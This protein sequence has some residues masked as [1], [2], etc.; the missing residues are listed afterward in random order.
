MTVG[1]VEDG[2]ADAYA[3][4]VRAYADAV[5]EEWQRPSRWQPGPQLRAVSWMNARDYAGRFLLE[6]LQNGHDAHPR[7]RGDG[8]VH[9]LLDEGEGPHGTLY[10]AN[11]G[12]PFLWEKVERVCKLAQSDKRVGEGIGNKGLGFR[13]VLEITES[14]EIYSDD[15]A[16]PGTGRL[17]GYR[18]RFAGKDD[19]R[20][21]LGGDDALVDMVV[22]EYPPLQVPFPV[23]ELP[24]TCA[25]LGAAGHVT[26][27]R[28]PLRSEAAG[29]E[30]ARRLKELARARTPVML[31]LDRLDRLVLERRKADGSV[32]RTDLVR[33]EKPAGS[34]RTRDERG[35]DPR[36]APV[37]SVSRVGLGELGEFLVAR[38]AVPDQRLRDTVADAVETGAL[39]ESWLRWEEAAVVEVALPAG[40]EADRRGQLYTFLP[41]G[42]DMAAPL[43]GHVNAPFFT[44]MDRTDL[45]REHPLNTMLYD[46]LAET[47]LLAAEE[48]RA[49]PGDVHRAAAVDVLGWETGAQ[50]AGL[51]AT[52]ARR[53]HGRAFEDV[54]LVP[55]LD[56]AGPGGW[57]TPREAVLWPAGDLTTLTARS[58]GAVGIPVADPR[59]GGGRMRRLA[60]VCAYLKCPLEPSTPDRAG[61]VERIVAVLPPPAPGEP[62]G[63]WDGVYTDLT[64]LFAGDGAA[65]RGRKLLLADDG[66]LGRCNAGHWREPGTSGRT[67]RR[68]A[69]FQ[70]VRGEA[71]HRGEPAVPDVLGK[72]LFYLHSGLLGTEEGGARHEEARFFLELH[73]LVRKFDVD[74]LLEHVR[75]ALGESS[76]RRL[77]EQA[78]KFVFRLYRSRG[79]ARPLAVK[80]L[81]LYVPSAAGSTILAGTAA[82][83][84]GWRGTHGDDLAAV[85]DE[86][87]DA[88]SD[89][90]GLEARLVAPPTAFVGRG[91][92]LEEW[93]D[94]LRALGVTDG[95]IPVSSGGVDATAHGSRLHTGSLVRM[96]R[97]PRGVVEQWEPFV[98]RGRGTVRYPNTPYRGTPFHR[99][100]GQEVVGG[101]SEPGRLAYARLVLHGLSH[102]NDRRFT[103][104]WT[105]ARSGDKDPRKVLTPLR[106]FVEE[107]PWLPVRGRDR[108]IAFVRPADAWHHP[109]A[110]EEEPAFAPTVA[111]RFRGLLD[112]GNTL[113][114][115]RELG[116]PT[117]DEPRDSARLVAYLGRAVGAGL[118]GP[119]DR[120]AVQRANQRAWKDLTAL[121]DARLRP[122]NVTEPL[123]EA[124]LLVEEGERLV[125]LDVETLGEGGRTL[126]V[127]GE[128]DTLAARLIRE[129]SNPLLVVPGAGKAAAGLLRHLCPDAIRLV[130]E[131]ELSVEVDGGGEGDDGHADLSALGDPLTDRLPWLP[132]AVGALADHATD[133]IRPTD[134]TLTRLVA[135]VRGLRLYGYESLRI[136]FDGTP[137]RL[138]ERLSGILPL[139][140]VRRPLILAPREAARA[141]DWEAVGRLAEA[142]AQLAGQP[143]AALRLR[144]AAHE[145]RTAYSDIATP[146][147]DVLARALGI[148]AAQLEETARRLDGSVAGVLERCLPVLAHILGEPRAR[149]LLDP[150]PTDSREL[151]TLLVP[152]RDALPLEPKDLVAAARIARDVDELRAAAGIDFAEFNRTLTGLGP[153]YRPISRSESHEEAVRLHVDLHRSR[154]VD[155]L[156]W[157]VLDRFDGRRPTA[158]D[159]PG[160][161]SL[162]WI[163]A[164]DSWALTKEHAD[165]ASLRSHIEDELTRRLG[166]SAP[167]QGERLPALE[168]VRS[169]N[170]ALVRGLTGEAVALVNAARKRLPPAL[171]APDPAVEITTLL[172]RAGALDFRDLTADDVLAWLEALGQWPAGMPPTLDAT[173]HGLTAEDLDRVRDDAER[174]REE[175]VRRRSVISFGGTEMDVAAG[176]FTE[177]ASEL[178]RV[179]EAGP[180]IVQGRR[181]FAALQEPRARTGGPTGSPRPGRHPAV[182]RGLSAA[183]RRAI[184]FIGEWFAYRWLREQHEAVNET[185]WVSS[186]RRSVFPGSPGDD[187]LGF[188][189]RVG[190][191]RH[192]L[193]YEVK[194]TQGEGGQIELGESEVRAAQRFAGSER[195]RILAITSVLDPEG[196]GV[197][198]LPNPFSARGRGVYREE[199]GALRFS[200]RM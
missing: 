167:L 129:T 2:S 164:P 86:G 39:D 47:C 62:V 54:P 20:V 93:R 114:R 72:R 92:T 131:A 37:V 147:E 78:L 113:S 8:H 79:P 185:S 187:T 56:P 19:L 59:V 176:D 198:V 17:D 18:F 44:K 7:D 137:I 120:P 57:T 128:R 179:L 58:A 200:Y 50:Y 102:W 15:P 25:E 23:D 150:P 172:D 196:L 66:T 52:A 32:D 103:S 65:L 64:Q 88:S 73:G 98:G 87:R 71:G 84:A 127:S 195:W 108:A 16:A 33:E 191:G 28:L 61:Y 186:N 162:T 166:R 194:A 158:D 155:R 151:V 96:A 35:R 21:L 91:E 130:D 81:G 9:V 42:D 154:L 95:L 4:E 139:P 199:G 142:A 13:S 11:G 184:G 40:G 175:R 126:Y 174:A 182:D 178:Q 90:R 67:A 1:R 119:E 133:G 104:L 76:A 177:L 38:G 53:A 89:L 152:H 68:E 14:P 197:H 134:T 122:W 132:L 27:V 125:T 60:R 156:R 74:G 36:S 181:G 135:T 110:P 136:S 170:G 80:Q 100:P 41:L 6:L 141:L 180:G 183:Q 169:R 83:G 46:A 63:A 112:A 143:S 10:V 190:S 77:R 12:T 99:L 146:S 107:Q 3:R 123:A 118:I 85:V 193:M 106:A 116:L 30:T 34:A 69:F 5:L 115:L 159:W 26:V 144:L 140:G 70:P 111:R 171:A 188:D 117:W 82:F 75:L 189:F 163:G 153:P 165:V 168:P 94:F 51:L 109:G 48:W 97:A 29:R 105:R 43:R 55:V 160:L 24:V 157:A 148:S 45:D 161:R 121:P 173:A 49:L 192:P 31:F 145:L 22:R 101:F 149:D 124:S 138:P